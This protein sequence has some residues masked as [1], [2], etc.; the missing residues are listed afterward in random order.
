[1]KQKFKVL[2]LLFVLSIFGCTLST[3][4]A[5]D[6]RDVVYLK[7]G[8]V[9]KGFYNSFVMN[10]TL[11]MKTLD[12]SM[13]VCPT[14]DIV[15]IAK[16]RTDVYVIQRDDEDILVRRWRPK[17]YS[18]SFEITHSFVA[19]YSRTSGEGLA[20]IHGYQFNRNLFLGLGFGYERY[21]I[22]SDKIKVVLDESNYFLF[23]EGRWYVMYTRIAPV[24]SCRGGYCFNGFRGPFVA[25]GIGVDV[26]I[27]PRFGCY[28]RF[29]YLWQK[30]K[31]N[32]NDFTQLLPDLEREGNEKFL[33]FTGG[34]HF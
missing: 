23:T 33:V 12:G 6:Y 2:S 14:S 25:P 24:V 3:C 31:Y 26:S 16:E 7:N 27:T 17:G 28:L 1:M 10:D 34:I 18:G 15:R 5:Q 8:S 11:R 4:F 29:Q 20:T 30:A 19:Q 13:L 9:I 32:F 21:T 22:S